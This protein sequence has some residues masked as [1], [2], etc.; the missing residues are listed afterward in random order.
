MFPDDVIPDPLLSSGS[1]ITLEQP[2]EYL[3]QLQPNRGGL[4]RLD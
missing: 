3:K 2:L 1:G 4:G